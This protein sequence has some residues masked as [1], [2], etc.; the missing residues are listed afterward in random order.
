MHNI[1]SYLYVKVLKRSL[2]PGRHD[3]VGAILTKKGLAYL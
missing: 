1:P 3:Q 2:C